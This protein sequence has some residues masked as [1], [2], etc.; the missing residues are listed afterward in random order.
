MAAR[1]A[2]VSDPRVPALTRACP[3]TTCRI[4]L[5][6]THEDV[7][8]HL[9]F[10]RTGAVIAGAPTRSVRDYFCRS[11][12]AAWQVVSRPGRRDRIQQRP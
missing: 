12:G 4:E 10:D 6:R 5:Q 8:G 1:S 11:C 9:V 2:S 7:S 3:E